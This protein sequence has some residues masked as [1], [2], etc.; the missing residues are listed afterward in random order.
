MYKMFS[1]IIFLSVCLSVFFTLNVNAA[2]RSKRSSSSGGNSEEAKMAYKINDMLTRGQ[3]LIVQ[4]QEDRGLELLTS[5][6]KMY[7]KSTL[8]FKAYLI[9]GQHYSKKRNYELA[10]KQFEAVEISEDNDQ[11]AEAVYNKGICYFHLADYNKSFSSLRKV[12]NEYP[13][14]IYANES[15]YYIGMCHFKLKRWSRSIEALEMVGA[16]VDNAKNKQVMAEAGHRL[17]VKIKDEDLV[18]MIEE[19]KNISVQVKTKSGDVEKMAVTPLG[20]SGAYYIGSVITEPGNSKPNDGILQCVGG[21]IATVLYIDKNTESGKQ[22]QSVLNTVKF[23]ST[24]TIGFTDGAYRDYTKGILADQPFFIRVK[25]LDKDKSNNKDTLT[26]SVYTEFKV[27]KE[28][29]YEKKGVNLE[30]IEEE[31]KTRDSTEITL[32]ETDSHSGIFTGSSQLK[33]AMSQDAYSPSDPNLWT[34]K[35]DNIILEYK[36]QLHI[37]GNEPREVDFK[38]K[39]LLG[40]LQ[41]VK[42]E[43]REVDS[44]EL[45]ARKDIIEGKIFLKLS[46]IFKDVGLLKQATKKAN[47]GLQRT[48]SVI[49]IGMKAS[50]DREIIE[51]AF[52]IKWELLI[53]QDKLK[54]AIRVCNTL[55]KLF[56]DSSLVDHALMKIAMAKIETENEDDMKDA[57]QILNS[58]TRLPKSELKPEAQYLIAEAE[59]KRAN[60]MAKKSSTGVPNLSRAMMAYKKCADNYPDSSFAGDA[61]DK[62]ANYYIKVKDYS[63]ASQLMEQIF[64]DYPDAS[65][66]DEMLLKWIIVAY[67]SGQFDLA[68]N[69]CEQLLEEYPNSKSA[70]KAL[71]FQKTIKLKLGR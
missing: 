11:K 6:P 48:K 5:I 52:N 3:E 19:K 31:W 30:D 32:V 29:D 67:R 7:P 2:R 50:M 37:A 12:I 45:Q 62:I 47:E 9:I 21:D 60:E 25:D 63:R 68:I 15:Y 56:P 28:V 57:M 42:I 36:D 27:E 8:R 49:E 35:N 43:H 23:V 38:A 54:E 16:S 14:S 46:Q 41:D 66:L 51:E 33:F 65:F 69:K 34:M 58:I 13:W 40:E 39:V 55:I 20:K 22:K 18:V 1:K 71:K 59:L 61:L 53:V 17:F 24:A 70:G 26:V 4:K 64:Q 10:I 44:L